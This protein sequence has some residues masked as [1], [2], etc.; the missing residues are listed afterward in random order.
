MIDSEYLIELRRRLLH[1]LFLWL[2]VF[3]TC[4]F[5]SESLFHS[6]A[7]P[8]LQ[9]SSKEPALIA[10]TVVAP[11]WVPIKFALATSF[12]VCIPYLFFQLWRFIAPA[13]YQQERQWGWALLIGSILLFYI[14]MSFVYFIV[15]PLLFNFFKQ[16]TP[17]YILFLPDIG[18]Y[19]S[20]VLTLF[21]AFGLSFQVPIVILLT[22]KLG[23]VSLTT[24]TKSRPYVI[25]GAFIMGM[26]LTPPDVLSQ[27]L[28][29]VPL[30]GLF[31]ITLGIAKWLKIESYTN[32]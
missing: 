14:G 1:C 8:L 24:L 18:H 6:L 23:V 5:F 2:P 16:F 27:I 9:Q 4:I 7:L 21:F 30:W 13:L 26:L 19:L 32:G 22:L 31:E 11:I 3:A 17:Q 15:L 20:F 25:V 12:F 10:T 29:A 28:L